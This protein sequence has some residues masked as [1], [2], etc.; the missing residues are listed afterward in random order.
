MLDFRIL[1]PLE[2]I[3]EG[4]PIR[5]G[6]PK[7]RATLAILLLN[8][9][10]VVSVDRLAD[11]LYAGAA[12]VTA[13][14][15]V[16][17]Q[18]SE[19]RKLLGP[20]HGIETHPPGYVLRLAPERLD[21]HRFERLAADA[22]RSLESDDARRAADLLRDALDLWRGPPLADL[23]YESFA[24]PAIVRLEE[25]RLAVVEQRVD[26][27]LALGAHTQ[28][29]AELEQ[30][31]REHPLQ[32]RFAEQLMVAL[33]RS[34]RQAEALDVYRSTRKRLVELLGLEP[35]EAL[36]ALERAIL[37]H[38]PALEPVRSAPATA[39]VAVLAVVSGADRLD[40]L[41]AV[42]EPLGRLPGQELIVACLV[43]D[44]GELEL[45]AAAVS[46]RRTSLTAPTRAAVFTTRDP[47][48]DVVRL[49]G[50]N[51]V[52]LVLLD[53]PGGLDGEQLPADLATVLE[54]APADVGVLSA[55]TGEL[56][57]AGVVVPFGG[58]EH[59]WAALELGAWL[60][61][62]TAA[63]LSLVGTKAE[64]SSGRR[65]ASR[66]LADASL[67]AQRVVG[68][69]TRPVLA[70][71]TEDALVAAVENAS[72]VVTGLSP[73][74]RREGIGATRRALVRRARPP[75]LLVHR[76]PRPSALAPREARTRFTWTLEA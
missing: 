55:R 47:P 23:A 8:A 17:R 66:L 63:S 44:E 4:S 64:S 33:Y 25:L 45:E 15:Q 1:G 52:G 68:V 11:D 73:R 42:A 18:V 40:A 62:A 26:A 14:T 56:A 61:S 41:L 51:D 12:P 35:T 60:A 29:I 31:V 7:Q 39:A 38:E 76:G 21:L 54:R 69:E 71:P 37:A 65:D 9:N 75:V 28:V 27:E 34:G 72:L 74:W 22:S 70:E 2:V 6:G 19:L 53:A 57:G 46:R 36:Q 49:A 32:E 67:A 50:G 16:Q 59:D 43:P 20:A 10:R 48:E 30:L 5:L 58:G 3:A 24:Q 13:V